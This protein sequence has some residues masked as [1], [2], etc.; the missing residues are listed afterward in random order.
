MRESAVAGWEQQGCGWFGAAGISSHTDSAM[1]MQTSP[2][3][4]VRAY[5]HA[6]ACPATC[7]GSFQSERAFAFA[8]YTPRLMRATF[9]LRFSV[10]ISI[11]PASHPAPPRPP[12]S[13]SSSFPALLS[14][15]P[16]FP[17]SKLSSTPTPRDLGQT[18]R[19]QILA[20]L[21]S[22]RGGC[23]TLRLS[24]HPAG[25]FSHNQRQGDNRRRTKAATCIGPWCLCVCSSS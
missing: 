24:S 1:R 16:R 10:P 17:T 2:R 15:L 18:T 13:S 22:H 19:P 6:H 9:C 5:I 14:P 23:P 8:T 4:R 20:Q 7:V 21:L 11:S 3:V 25:C 12:F